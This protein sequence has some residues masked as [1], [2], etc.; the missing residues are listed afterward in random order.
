MQWILTLRLVFENY[1]QYRKH[2]FICSV[3]FL[4]T[5]FLNN[6]QKKLAPYMIALSRITHNIE[7]NYLARNLSWLSEQNR[8]SKSLHISVCNLFFFHV[9]ENLM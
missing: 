2:L 9:H 1:K 8:Q 6:Q 3:D 4:I 5:S 7:G